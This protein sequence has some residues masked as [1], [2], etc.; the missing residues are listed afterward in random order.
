MLS[1]I[2]LVAVLAVAAGIAVRW[3]ARLFWGHEGPMID[4]REL[5]VGIAVCVIVVAP[6]T[7]VVGTKVARANLLR[8]DEFWGGY[9][10][11]AHRTTNPCSRDGSCAHEYQCDPYQVLVT[12]T[13]SVSDGKGG[14][15]SET[16]TEME[17]R[18]HSCPYATE[19]W[20]FTLETTLGGYTI[21]SHGFSDHPVEWRAGSGI[22][23]GVARGVPPFWAAAKQRIDSGDP[24]PVTAV[25]QYDN[26]ILASQ[27]SI[28]K[29]HS[30]RIEE[31]EAEKLLPAPA[32]G[33]R[34]F[35]LAD[36]VRFVGVTPD[37]AWQDAVNRFNAAFGSDLQGDLHV[38]IVDAK[39]AGNPDAYTGALNA[40]WTGPTF[41]K[42]ALS[43]NALVVVLGAAQGNVVWSRAFT[44]MPLG[45]EKLLV[46]LSRMKGSLDA[47]AFV[48]R[49]RGEIARGD[50]KRIHHGA[51]AIE[52]AVWGPNQFERVCMTCK[53]EGGAG[54][55][56]LGG[57]IQPTSGQRT[58]I[59]LV[60]F[61]ICCAIWAA[62]LAVGPQRDPRRG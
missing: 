24:G 23:G 42:K 56:Y 12:K 48:G 53:E 19:E 9:E 38:V 7:A 54:F 40:Y 59:V 27:S 29:K 35:Y 25:R 15:R 33:V 46:E 60:G 62:L 17:T 58:V 55:T 50:V 44:G 32:T 28:L 1:L 18:Y 6:L 49:P 5:A 36:K 4:V 14:T 3:G 16:Y 10:V 52:S 13:R 39:R 43:K 41:K 37:P 20:S 34:D 51:G 30:D 2:L 31:L 26:Y 57:E 11:A 22:P 21:S 61:F 45:N 47:E 8:Y